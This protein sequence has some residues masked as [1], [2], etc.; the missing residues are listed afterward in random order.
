MSADS[1]LILIAGPA[2]PGDVVADWLQTN[3]SDWLRRLPGIESIDLFLPTERQAEFFDDGPAPGFGLQLC[4]ASSDI[5]LALQ[6]DRRLI[7]ACGSAPSAVYSI[8]Q[9]PVAGQTEVAPRTAGLSFLV[10][11]FAPIP[12]PS[13]FRAAYMERHPMLLGQFPQ[14]RNVRCY[15]PVQARAAANG[16]VELINEVV[17]DDLAALE[18]ALASPLMQSLAD[19]SASLPP[20]AASAHH[21]MLR[22]SIVT[23]QTNH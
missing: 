1:T 22:R 16:A 11:Y 17:F 2:Q 8:H 3:D 14:I 21:A 12:D 5:L 20:R 23:A 9:W 7:E 13:A 6:S 10:R 19:D 4:A 15:A 18:T